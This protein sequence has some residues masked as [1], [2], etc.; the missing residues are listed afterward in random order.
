MDNTAIKVIAFNSATENKS[1]GE[2]VPILPY[3]DAVLRANT[4][5][6]MPPRFS[7]GLENASYQLPKNMGG[8]VK[9]FLEVESESDP[10]FTVRTPLSLVNY[11]IADY[12]KGM[13]SAALC[14]EIDTRNRIAKDHNQAVT[15]IVSL[16]FQKNG[17]SCANGKILPPPEPEEARVELT[18]YVNDIFAKKEELYTKVLAYLGKRGFYCPR[19]FELKDAVNFANDVADGEERQK[20]KEKG[21]KRLNIP[22]YPPSHWDGVSATDDAGNKIE[23]VRMP[24]HTFLSPHMEVAFKE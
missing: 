14:K 19:D 17:C 6:V 21:G 23:W 4:S 3:A 15:G 1:S 2:Y 20:V 11:C 16:F 12:D 22:A 5:G 13:P 8:D 18:K 10:G 9:V 7:V 24:D